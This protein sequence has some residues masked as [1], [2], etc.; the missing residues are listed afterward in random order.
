MRH[1]DA[2][3][4]PALWWAKRKRNAEKSAR[5]DEPP[6]CVDRA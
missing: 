2:D 1:V 4:N 6:G 3:L 5:G